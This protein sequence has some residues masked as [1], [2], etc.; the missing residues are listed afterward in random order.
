MSS[1]GTSALNDREPP[2]V[3]LVEDQLAARQWEL[4]LSGSELRAGRRAWPTPPVLAYRGW[5][6]RLWAAHRTDASPELLSEH[7]S[8]ALWQAVIADSPEAA[9]LVGLPGLARWAHD[10]RRRLTGWQ[11][12][13]EADAGAG[14]RDA[15]FAAFLRWRDRYAE[16]LAEQRW[17]D[18]AG[19]DA[20][21][22]DG[23]PPPAEPLLIG[24]PFE[25]RPSRRALLDRLRDAGWPIRAHASTPA[26]AVASRARLADARQELEA[27]AG[28]AERWLR[29]SPRDR[30]AVVIPDLASRVAEVERALGAA[31]VGPE[32]RYVSV[33]E[34]R[35]GERPLIGAALNALELLSPDGGFGE[36]SRWL[37]SPFFGPVDPGEAAAAARLEAQWRED[38]AAQ[39]SFADAYR[40]AGFRERLERSAP[41]FA[42]RLEAARAELGPGDARRAPSSWARLWQQAL[43]HLGWSGAHGAGLA[44][45]E[46]ARD[47]ERALGSLALLTPVLGRL[48]LQGA[49]AELGRILDGAGATGPLPLAGVHVLGDLADIG[50]GYA[51][52]WVTGL[53]A[54]AFPRPAALNPLLP[55]S[56]QVRHGMPWSSP[57]DALARSRGL[58]D[59]LRERVGEVVFSWPARE[60]DEETE[61]S[62]L[63]GACP[64]L[65]LA[66]LDTGSLRFAPAG[67]R[68]R[69]ETAAD[70]RAPAAEGALSGGTRAL[71]ATARCP[72]RAFCEHRLG[73]RP[74]AP[75]TRGLSRRLKGIAL[76]GALESVY[77]RYGGQ[78]ALAGVS[79]RDLREALIDC[80]Q[81]ALQG[82]F[83]AARRSLGTLFELERERLV[84]ILEN[85]LHQEMRR[86]P[87]EIT[88]LEQPHTLSVGRWQIRT[89]IDRIDLLDDGSLAVIDY[90]SGRAGRPASWFEPRLEDS[91]L[92]VYALAAGDQVSA[93]V[94]ASLGGAR[95]I[96]YTGVWSRREDFPGRPLRPPDRR[97]LRA[98]I[99]LW[100]EAIGRLVADFAAGDVG[101]YAA[102]PD[103]AR[104][105]F[106]PLTRVQEQLALRH[107]WIEPW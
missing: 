6:E 84:S 21:L 101:V 57:Q 82:V 88:A 58:L 63:I 66:A 35:L 107:G 106:A 73:A 103:A 10:A 97:E 28:W 56:L 65:D 11:I 29:R 61:P 5:T 96:G 104:G 24:A 70:A 100:R 85:F 13:A 72:L 78:A 59:A 14:A 53:T 42:A 45:A 102:E 36:L 93:L 60:N 30:V 9:G 38:L 89:R 50:P 81:A 55:R 51:A 83:G 37:R 62:P 3:I 77:R 1:N 69:R 87:F 48:S 98:Q 80:A 19:L 4:Y 32:A 43:R 12:A 74:L 47:W 52:A 99:P 95:G 46:Q 44:D 41:T 94:I 18:G 20:A 49:L 90:K 33:S 79:P 31:G 23:P 25:A 8:E 2:T 39:L 67:S 27:A 26:A 75:L 91:Q 68:R 22:R 16:R 15:D 76:H 40:R 7:Q 92:P 105:V 71:D 34:T 86:S 64:S 17:I 54:T